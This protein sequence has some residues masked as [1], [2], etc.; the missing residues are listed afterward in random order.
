MA[1]TILGILA[2][3]GGF[4]LI[5]FSLGEILLR[6]CV[7]LV[8]LWLINYGFQLQGRGSLYNRAYSWFL[9]RKF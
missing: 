2:I 6:L 8:G 7:A 9:Y 1:N 4:V 3:I 5:F